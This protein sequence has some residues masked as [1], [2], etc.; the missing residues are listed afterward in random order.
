V[1]FREDCHAR[2]QTYGELI[3]REEEP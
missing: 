1:R 2:A 3:P